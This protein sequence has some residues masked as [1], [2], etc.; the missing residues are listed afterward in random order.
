MK[1]RKVSKKDI[2]NLVKKA[3][4]EKKLIR[5]MS[6]YNRVREHI[7]GDKS[8][9]VISSDRHERTQRDWEGETNKEAYH[10]LLQNVKEAGLTYIELKGGFKETTT[11]EVDPE[12]GEEVEVELEEPVH[13]TENSILVTSYGRGEDAEEKTPEEL[14]DFAEEMARKYS[15]EAFIF[16]E[17]AATS[18]GSEFKIMHAYDKDGNR[19]EESWAGPWTS[20]QTVSNADDFWSR[21]SGKH[22][23]LK[24][25]KKTVQPKS[26]IEAMMKSKKGFTW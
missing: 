25:S 14:F 6:S 11:T 8:F 16:G 23:Q 2:F 9:V 20:V 24:E 22:F 17:P 5:E 15:Q 3:L 12:T 18:R 13:V 10:Q 4:T 26:W 1:I 7:E 19:I 21:A